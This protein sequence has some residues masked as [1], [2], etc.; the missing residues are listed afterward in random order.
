MANR[1]RAADTVLHVPSGETWELGCDETG[2]RVLPNGWPSTI[3]KASD[4]KLVKAATDAERDDMLREWAGKTVPDAR[5]SAAID[6]LAN[7]PH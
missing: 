1:F 3:A 6:Q 7:D 2:G 4:C 5:R